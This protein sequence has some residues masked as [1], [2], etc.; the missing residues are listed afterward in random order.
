MDKRALW[1]KIIGIV[2]LMLMVVGFG[3]IMGGGRR[4]EHGGLL[5]FGIILAAVG[6]IISES[7]SRKLVLWGAGGTAASMIPG[8]ISGLINGLRGNVE[9]PDPHPIIMAIIVL[10]GF[11]SQAA[12]VFGTIGIILRERSD[13]R[14][15][16]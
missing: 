6:A 9:T 8:L 10:V 1:S 3:L 7:S 12:I 11:L 15:L 13:Q 2:A 14:C 5:V 16:Q 4:L